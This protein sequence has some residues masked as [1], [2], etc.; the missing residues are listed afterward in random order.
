MTP[1]FKLRTLLL[2]LAILPPLLAVGWWKYTAW[3]AGQERLAH[4]RLWLDDGTRA[5]TLLIAPISSRTSR[6]P[7]SSPK[8]RRRRESRI[9]FFLPRRHVSLAFGRQEAHRRAVGG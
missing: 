4:T 2:M 3:R 8:R 6:Q 9:T 7:R 1:R 5:T